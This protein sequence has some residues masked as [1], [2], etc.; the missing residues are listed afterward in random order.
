MNVKI[1]PKI[2][3]MITNVEN[4]IPKVLSE[5]L[6]LWLEQKITKCPITKYFCENIKGTCNECSILAQKQK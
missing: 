2:L 4:D 1:E 3:S 5:A 6:N